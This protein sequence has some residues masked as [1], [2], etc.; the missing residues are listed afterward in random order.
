MRFL[1]TFGHL[2][3]TWLN[4][5][6]ILISGTTEGFG[7]AL[8]IPL[9]HFMA[10][11]NLSEMPKPFSNILDGFEGIGIVPGVVTLLVM[12]AGLALFSLGLAYLQRKVLAL[13]KTRH[14]GNLRN[15]LFHSFL[16]SSWGHSS[17]RSHGEV[18][19]L[20][21]LECNRAGGALGFELMAVATSVLIAVYLT[22]S[23]FIS[24]QLTIIS[25]LFGVLMFLIIR[26]FSRHAKLLGKRATT[27]NRTFGVLMVE[28]LRALKLLKATA[29]EEQAERKFFSESETLRLNA[30]NS[31]L[32]VAKVHFISQALPLL[33]LTIV[34]GVSNKIL[35]IPVPVILVFLLFLMRIAP[36]AGQL[37]QQL[38]SYHLLSP[39]IGVVTEM[40]D[41]SAK[42]R[43]DINRD[44]KAFDGIKESIVLDQVTFEYSGGDAPAVKDVSLSI[45]CNQI[46]AIVGGS[47]AGK[48]TLIDI[49]TGLQKPDSG[50]VR[51]DGVDLNTFDLSSWRR[52]IGIVTQ[53]TITLN[54]SLRENLL[55]FNPDASDADI[56][57][58]VSAAHLDG[59]VANLPDGLDTVLGESGVRFSGGQ[60]QR[61]ALARALV[62][63]PELL[64]LD[65][66]TS[67]LD[68]ESERYVQDAIRA[69]ADTMTVVVVAHRLSTVRRADIIY[70]LE[71]GKLVESGNYTELIKL[72]GRFAELQMLESPE[73]GVS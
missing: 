29:S 30:V 8:F 17:R 53:E 5:F 20:L 42:A 35:E 49:L 38:Q 23:I 37:Q 45:G 48:S 14:A 6:L 24:W 59:V 4:L 64:L 25:G 34:I 63:K 51:V 33:L 60:K 7:L 62:G 61:I 18:V 41:S 10:G 69:A 22:F 39:A 11:N 73:N 19:N 9:L 16:R 21:A 26:P 50:E 67:A 32:N 44:G 65:E 12:I 68:N 31:E 70:V 66:A 56:A 55:F 27:A 47:G 43:E 13:A 36:R 58:A 1:S 46:V 2:P 28:Y 52:R 72:G 54:A 40:I 57:V 3:N 71:K 15:T